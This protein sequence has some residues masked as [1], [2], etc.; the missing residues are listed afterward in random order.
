MPLFD[1]NSFVGKAGSIAAG[2]QKTLGTVASSVNTIKTAATNLAAGIQ[3]PASFLKGLL[4][5]G[6]PPG[7]ET[8]L[9]SGDISVETSPTTKDDWRVSLSLPYGSYWDSPIMAPII[10]SDYKLIFPYTP[11]IS[12]SHKANYNDLA[13][14][15]NNYPFLSYSNSSVDSI[16]IEAPFLIEDAVE[17]AYWIAAVHYFRSVSK[18]YSGDS[19]FAGAPPPIVKLRG[20]G[21]HVL[22]SVPV[23]IESFSVSLPDDVDY[24]SAE[25]AGQTSRVPAKSTFTIECKPIYSREAVRNFSLTEFVNGGYLTKGGKGFI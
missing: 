3:D 4:G 14:I 23:V 2:A 12:I 8:F 22:N 25:L 5:G 19:E 21:N 18:M 16:S 11:R 1:V 20:Y 17:G 7:A 6:L 13:P 9:S 10:S 15:H 24:I